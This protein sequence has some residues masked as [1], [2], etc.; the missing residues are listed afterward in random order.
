MAALLGAS[1][2]LFGELTEEVRR[3]ADRTVALRSRVVRLSGAVDRA[4]AAL[5]QNRKLFL[6]LFFFFS[7]SIID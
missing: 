4:N 6:F 7:Y 5:R 1:D 2:Q 3:L